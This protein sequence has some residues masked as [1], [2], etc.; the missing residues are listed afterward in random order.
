[1][2]S[3]YG[4]NSEINYIERACSQHIADQVNL[5]W[6][7]L[8]LDTKGIASLEGISLSSAMLSLITVAPLQ[9]SKLKI[10]QTF[11]VTDAI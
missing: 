7:L 5:K 11:K 2:D 8:T 10:K 9:W 1:M 4:G 6:A 3:L